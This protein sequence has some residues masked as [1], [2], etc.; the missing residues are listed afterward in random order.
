MADR[1]FKKQKFSDFFSKVGI[2]GYKVESQIR[3]I[4]I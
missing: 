1:A 3:G 2:K 4:G